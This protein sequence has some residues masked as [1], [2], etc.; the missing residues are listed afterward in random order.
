MLSFGGQSTPTGTEQDKKSDK[1]KHQ[2]QSL[3]YSEKRE[4]TT[5]GINRDKTHLLVV[6]GGGHEAFHG[7][8]FALV[9]FFES[10]II[11]EFSGEFWTCENPDDL[12]QGGRTE[13]KFGGDTPYVIPEVV[14]SK[15]ATQ[16][17]WIY[18]APAD[19]LNNVYA[20]I[21]TKSDPA[22]QYKA[23][24]GD[25]IIIIFI[26]HGNVQILPGGTKYIRIGLQIGDEKMMVEDFVEQLRSIPKSVQVNVISNGCYS[27]IFSERVQLDGQKDRW[28]EATARKDEKAWPADRS[29]SDRFR[30]GRFIA[31]LVRSLGGLATSKDPV[32]LKVVKDN[33]LAATQSHHDV[34]RRNM[35]AAYHD[36]RETANVADL[37]FRE[38]A[39]FPMMSN[40]S[41]ARRRDE[42]TQAYQDHFPTPRSPPPESTI[43]AL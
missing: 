34:N 1:K 12:L 40:N 17:K 19:L 21:K 6:N 16:Q 15:G 30:S 32:S 29:K 8:F 31:G 14:Y 10:R 18:M 7:D 37:L 3:G 27:G 23:D 42:L 11:P 35:L 4:L 26:A 33:L 38:Y 24:D 25:A 9:K 28:I 20:W 41:A 13:I 22:S 5:P 39:D 2:S 36:A 43:S